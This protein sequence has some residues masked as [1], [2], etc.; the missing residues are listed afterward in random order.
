[1]IFIYD[2]NYKSKIERNL[3]VSLNYI[4]LNLFWSVCNP[5]HQVKWKKWQFWFTKI[6]DIN[7]SNKIITLLTS[8]SAALK[9][10]QWWLTI[11][12]SE[13]G[14]V[15]L[16]Q[17][18]SKKLIGYSHRFNL[19]FWPDKFIN[20]IKRQNYESNHFFIQKHLRFIIS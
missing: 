2:F 18:V 11:Y 16:N 4:D 13:S 8:R 6:Y 20:K 10:H 15:F 14:Y 12:W 1:M 9:R 5:L 17:S 7:R 19:G 3:M